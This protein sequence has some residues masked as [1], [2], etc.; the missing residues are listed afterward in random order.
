MKFQK[1]ISNEVKNILIETKGYKISSTISY[2]YIY[3]KSY[4]MVIRNPLKNNP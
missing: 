3:L 2:I 4:R 1:S